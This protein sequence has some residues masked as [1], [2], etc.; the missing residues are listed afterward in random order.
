MLL[1]VVGMLWM[2]VGGMVVLEADRR[3][4]EAWWDF[5]VCESARCG[6][7]GLSE[8]GEPCKPRAVEVKVKYED[9]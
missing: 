1:R 6:I 3:I 8:T 2:A 4:A 5:L 7:I 9:K